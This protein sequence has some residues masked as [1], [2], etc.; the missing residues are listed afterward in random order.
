MF[1]FMAIIGSSSRSSHFFPAPRRTEGDSHITLQRPQDDITTVKTDP[2][3]VKESLEG[4][5]EDGFSDEENLDL[6]S[7]TSSDRPRTFAEATMLPRKRGGR[8]GRGDENEILTSPRV[9]EGVVTFKYTTKKKVK[10]TKWLPLDLAT[11]APGSEA[12]ESEQEHIEEGAGEEIASTSEFV[13]FEHQSPNT[14]IGKRAINFTSPNSHFSST[15]QSSK[16]AKSAFSNFPTSEQIVAGQ[17][18]Y[19]GVGLK[20]SS[21]TQIIAG[22]IDC[23]GLKYQKAESIFTPTKGK[24]KAI[25]DVQHYEYTDPYLD[26]DATPTQANFESSAI[27]FHDNISPKHIQQPQFISLDSVLSNHCDEPTPTLRQTIF[28]PEALEFVENGHDF[29]A[30]SDGPDSDTQSTKDRTEAAMSLLKQAM[31]SKKA[32][33][34]TEDIFDSAEWMPEYPDIENESPDHSPERVAL[35]PQ[36]VA[37]TTVGSLVNPN[38][39]P[40]FTAPNRIQRE[41]ANRRPLMS[42]LQGR[43]YDYSF[44]QPRGPPPPLSM[45]NS[46]HYAQQLTRSPPQ[47]S[48]GSPPNSTPSLASGPHL[49][50]L[51]KEVLLRQFGQKAS[52]FTKSVAS[53][54]PPTP[55]PA[56]F[57]LLELSRQTFNIQ[58]SENLRSRSNSNQ[59]SLQGLEKMQTLQ[60]LA[61]FE[62]PMQELAR[63]RLSEF[64]VIKP[65][66]NKTIGN[67]SG[68]TP[69][70]MLQRNQKAATTLKT[71]NIR[72]GDELDYGFKFPPPPSLGTT[73]TSQPNPLLSMYSSRSANTSHHRPS[74]YPQPLTAG[75]PGQRQ[76]ASSFSNSASTQH[77]TWLTDSGMQT[78]SQYPSHPARS[79]SPWATSPYLSTSH[80]MAPNE[81]YVQPP[82]RIPSGISGVAT[83]K[84]VDTIPITE[85]QKWYPN[86][87]PSEINGLYTPLSDENREKMGLGLISPEEKAAQRAKDLDDIF[88]QGQCRYLTMGFEQHIQEL[89]ARQN[90]PSTYGPICPPKK[91]IRHIEVAPLTCEDMQKMTPAEVVGPLLDAAFGTLLG[92]AE[93][94]SDSRSRLSHF[95]KSPEWQ[96]DGDENGNRSLFGEDWGAPP[97]RFGRDP[98]RQVL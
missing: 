45:A 28:N 65:T 46:M 89:E 22:G 42:I 95:E 62:N 85:I 70:E 75:P 87:W 33:T 98:R 14:N 59:G 81:T 58:E 13:L 78:Y 5:I 55:A 32:P 66:S 79:P 51:E 29:L 20:F 19:P 67:P 41:G 64:S 8:R 9:L 91:V 38:A 52:Q 93:K 69:L 83:S 71:S 17:V 43:Q 74:G 72:N 31:G 12:G 76:Y 84:I 56:A 63:S 92:Y 15:H 11:S 40:Q 61:K 10:P 24:E 94:S 2:Y 68:L 57:S 18:E 82:N 90:A 73:Y 4:Q 96:I 35:K 6:T 48:S 23:G 97:K 25:A 86:G 54:N 50:D 44:Y 49:T 37:Y 3:V 47:G 60:R 77:H 16:S 27:S 36:P 34:P 7:P 21:S 88:Y 80:H 39:V 30:F 53:S 26:P 1:D